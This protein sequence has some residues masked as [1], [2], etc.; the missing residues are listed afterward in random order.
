MNRL[1]NVSDKVVNTD[2]ATARGDIFNSINVNSADS[3][4]MK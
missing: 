1:Y 3:E 4:Q 2:L